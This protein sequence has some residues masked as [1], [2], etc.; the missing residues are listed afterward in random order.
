MF[1]GVSTYTPTYPTI[2]PREYMSF[3]NINTKELFVYLSNSWRRIN[4]QKFIKSDWLYDEN[5][6]R[7][8]T[9]TGG[10]EI[11]SADNNW[12]EII[13]TVGAVFSP[14]GYVNYICYIAPGQTYNAYSTSI[15]PIIA[16]NELSFKGVFDIYGADEF[17][18]GIFP[19]GYV[20]N[21]GTGAMVAGGIYRENGKITTNSDITDSR[22]FVPLFESANADTWANFSIH[23]IKEKMGTASIGYGHVDM[24]QTHIGYGT[25][26]TNGYYLG[27][28]CYEGSITYVDHISIRREY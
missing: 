2:N 25:F 21:N 22:N 9:S 18:Y 7:I 19:S 11:V 6:L 15:I 26:P 8:N 24:I 3:Y 20:I 10:L 4:W 13:P 28:W 23:I 16:V 14:I 5:R 17:W 27:Y 1:I 12:H